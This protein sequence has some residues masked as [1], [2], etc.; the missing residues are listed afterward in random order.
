MTPTEDEERERGFSVQVAG[1]KLRKDVKCESEEDE[2]ENFINDASLSSEEDDNP[3]NTTL[4]RS[5]NIA[6]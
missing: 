2:D 1:I 5:V 4:N 6:S 3:L